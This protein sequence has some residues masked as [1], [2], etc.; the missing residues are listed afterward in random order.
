MILG[1]GIDL[2][3]ISRIRRSLDR[4]GKAWLDEISDEAEQQGLTAHTDLA[5][6]EA[7]AVAVKEASA[8]TLGVGM[9]DGVRWRDIVVTRSI[10]GISVQLQ[11]GAAQ[12][13]QAL[14]SGTDYSICAD[15]IVT[16]TWIVASAALMS[17]E[18]TSMKL[19]AITTALACSLQAQPAISTIQITA[20]RPQSGPSRGPL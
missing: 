3:R 5:L 11:G 16:P 2:C 14:A 4:F 1:I 10:D 15:A 7:I 18:T 6:T 20:D 8:K 9:A 17:S 12:Q 13:A 19:R